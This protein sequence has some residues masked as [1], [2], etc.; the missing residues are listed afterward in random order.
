MASEKMSQPPLPNFVIIGAQKSATRWLRLN[1]GKHPD[2]Y[3][4]GGEPSYFNTDLFVQGPGSYRE[5][6]SA[7]EGQQFVGESTPGYMQW[8][9]GPGRVAERIDALLP[10]V[11]LFAVLR[12]PVDRTYSAFIHHINKGRLDPGTDLFEYL[13]ATPS[14]KDALQLIA[15]STYATNLRPFKQTFGERLWVGLQD[16]VRDAPERVYESALEHLGVGDTGFR[17]PELSRVRFSLSAP[18]GSRYRERIE[19]G[20]PPLRAEERARLRAEFEPQ[21]DRLEKMFGLDLA[22]WR[23]S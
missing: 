17:P 11:R 22:R 6:F 16:D 20:K 4:V 15:G 19:A 23:A 10:G 3:T 8:N 18:A 9:G 13:D 7:W 12:N 1:L 21:V 14:K 2:V 5:L